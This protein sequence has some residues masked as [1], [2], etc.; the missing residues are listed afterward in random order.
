M[1]YVAQQL[2]HDGRLTRSISRHVIAEF[3][4]APRTDPETEIANARAAVTK[5]REQFALSSQ[6]PTRGKRGD[7]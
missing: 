4:D 3:E 2:G 1:R 6:R 7:R 5:S